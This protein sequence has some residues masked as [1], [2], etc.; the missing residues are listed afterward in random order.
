MDFLFPHPEY[1]KI[2]GAF[3]NQVYS[4]IQNKGQLLV[5]APT[6]IGKTAS[7]LSP[8][9]TYVLKEKKNKTIFFLTSRNTQH[10]IAIETLKK[11]KKKF[12]IELIAVDI[13]G[14]K[15]MCNQAGINLF[16]SNE[17]VE[18]CKD[19]REKGKCSYY[20]SLRTKGKI[21]PEAVN[22]LKKLKEESPMHVENMNSINF[23]SDLCSYE[24]AAF[25][26]K[27]AQVIIGDY[28][29]ILNPHIRDSLLKRINK[30]L[31]DCIIIFDEG[32]NIPTRARDLLSANLTS[33]IIE[34]AA[35]E[36][37]GLGYNE[38][39]ND[40]FQLKEALEKLTK[41]I[42]LDKQE[43][44][45]TKADFMKEVEKIGNYEEIMGN[46]VFVADQVLETKKRSFTQSVAQFMES[47]IGPDEGFVRIINKGFSRTGK[48]VAS[49]SYRCLDPAL[50]VKDLVQEAHA[51]VIMSGTL[52]P[53]EMYADLLGA[54]NNKTITIEYQNPFPQENRLNIILPETSTKYLTRS[55]T[56][57]ETIARKCADI[58]TTIPGN[59]IIFFPSYNIL[60]NVYE[61]FKEK[62]TKTIFI[63]DAELSKEQRGD[64]L[65]KFKDYNKTGAILLGVA[66]GSFAEGV[67]LPGDLLKGVIVVGLPLARP[68]I[69]TQE[70]INYY[71][72]RFGKGWDY[73]YTIPALIK[74]LQ[75]AG[76]CIRSETDRGVVIFMD[77]RYT[78]QNY[79]RC[80]SPDMNMKIEKNPIPL[81]KEF[82]QSQTL[83]K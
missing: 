69:E 73:G 9:L 70:L 39:A 14:K 76:R 42:S 65:E 30:S 71:D 35:K 47:W 10:L 68:D 4:A 25:L 60:E 32:H 41:K 67:D 48:G 37:K 77:E 20:E 45:L 62:S 66:G 53:I 16:R 15:N 31:G 1:R 36:T 81:I 64:L 3:M 78:W 40:I 28:N 61:F 5:H 51:L 22:V 74:T 24:M 21:S 58:T 6:G 12:G 63:E 44:I 29:Y 72:K 50:I 17:F 82:F 2:Q 83:L 8:A 46:C 52:T 18:F 7:A 54:D 13:I 23:N 55:K 49:I 33:F 38:M 59:S 75:S 34:A 19:L 26:G 56:M 80:F 27:E 43:I 79:K 57:W 11:I